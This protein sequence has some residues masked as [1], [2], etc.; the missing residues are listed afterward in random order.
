MQGMLA[1]PMVSYS[2]TSGAISV[3]MPPAVPQLT[4]LLVSNPT[5]SFDPAAPWFSLLDPSAQGWAF[6][7]TNRKAMIELATKATCMSCHNP[8]TRVLNGTPL[9]GPAYR[10][11][12]AQYRNDADAASKLVAQMKNGGQGKWGQVPMPPLASSVQPDD[13]QKLAEWIL[14]Y[15]WDAILAE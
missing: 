12:A 3:M 10:E 8:D 9:I 2:A 15:K 14:S 6:L 1:M 11:V 4:P 13:M 5:N 7:P